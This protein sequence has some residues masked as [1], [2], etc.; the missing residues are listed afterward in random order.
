LIAAVMNL[1]SQLFLF[2]VSGWVNRHQQSVVEYLQAENRALREQ[3]GPK[4]I[5]CTDAQRKM[6]A[7]NA[8]A[9]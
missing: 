6:L 3:L 7:E 1:Y 5:R 9:V 8:R 4:R 2:T